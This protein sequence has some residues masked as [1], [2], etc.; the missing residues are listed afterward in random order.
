M[1]RWERE[2]A[3]G[4]YS[5][6]QAAETIEE[7]IETSEHAFHLTCLSWAAE[8]MALFQELSEHCEE[9]NKQKQTDVLVS[10]WSDH[11]I[12]HSLTDT[13]S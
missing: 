7:L 1:G 13:H 11:S 6:C 8:L 9:G 3:P 12:A 10:C 2:Q 4:S 5:G